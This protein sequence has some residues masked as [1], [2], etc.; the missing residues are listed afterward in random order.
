MSSTLH[1]DLK[2]LMFPLNPEELQQEGWPQLWMLTF[3]IYF[4][5]LIKVC[6]IQN[7]SPPGISGSRWNNSPTCGHEKFLVILPSTRGE[8]PHFL[9]GRGRCP[10]SV[11]QNP[12]LPYCFVVVILEQKSGTRNC[13]IFV[14]SLADN[15]FFISDNNLPQRLHTL[16]NLFM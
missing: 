9:R 10:G 2:K 1:G 11:F 14:T 12:P 13:K 7:N 4:Y 5:F 15:F 16:L 8:L 3:C 6:K